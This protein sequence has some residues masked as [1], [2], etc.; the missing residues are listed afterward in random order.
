MELLN[1]LLE[2]ALNLDQ[3]L[4]QLV[5]DYG[6][7]IYVILFLIVFMETGL[8]F[9]AFL[10][11]DVLLF[12]AG[13]FCAGVQ[14]DIGQTTELNLAIILLSLIIAAI[15]G[16]GLNYYIGKNMGLKVLHWKIRNKLLVHP[17]YILKTNE[18]Y[19]HHGAKTIIIA[20]FLPIIRTFAPFVAGIGAMA[21]AK[22]VR[23]NVMGAFIWVLS[24]VLLGYFFGNLPFVKNN[25]ETVIFGIIILSI[26]PVLIEIFRSKIKKATANKSKQFTQ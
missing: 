14:N 21:Y 15:L 4:F 25:F 2:F 7:W 9:M 17:K 26:G 5:F 24:L 13:A 10:P 12:T 1:T 6:F 3:H 11:G 18:F 19:E 22:F 8:V 23:Y 16:D 20:R